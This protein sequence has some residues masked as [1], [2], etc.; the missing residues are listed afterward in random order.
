MVTIMAIRKHGKGSIEGQGKRKLTNCG[1]VF[2]SVLV[3]VFSYVTLL[4]PLFAKC[5]ARID[6]KDIK[7]VKLLLP[8]V[9]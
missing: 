2:Y 1:S 8:L 4:F 9:S 3:T 6:R 5:T 7:K